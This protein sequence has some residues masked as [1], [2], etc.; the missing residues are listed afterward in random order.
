MQTRLRRGTIIVI[1][2]KSQRHLYKLLRWIRCRGSFFFDEFNR[3]AV[4][5]EVGGT[6]GATRHMLLEASHERIR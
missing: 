2:Q 5:I 3:V 6:L 1:P 4:L